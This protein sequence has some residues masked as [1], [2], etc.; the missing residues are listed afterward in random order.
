MNKITDEHIQAILDNS[1]FVFTTVFDKC[2]IVACKLP[3]GY[4]IVE[5]AACIDPEMY[6][7]EFGK[8]MCYERIISKVWELEG[9]EAHNKNIDPQDA[10]RPLYFN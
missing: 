6:D 5:E 8:Q 3:N 4:V 10:A 7:E 1:E 2:M 9:Y